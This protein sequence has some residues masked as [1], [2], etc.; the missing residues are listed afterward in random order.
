MLWGPTGVGKSLLAEALANE[1][2]AH[3]IILTATELVV[4][5]VWL[6]GDVVGV[7]VC[8]GLVLLFQFTGW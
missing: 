4:G 2:S 6:H 7:R 8:E 3:S 1:T 5:W